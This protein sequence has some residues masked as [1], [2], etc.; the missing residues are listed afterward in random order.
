MENKMKNDLYLEH[1]LHFK[2]TWGARQREC[3]ECYKAHKAFME[4]SALFRPRGGMLRDEDINFLGNP[5]MAR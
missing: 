2:G 3:S 1:S 4:K 5:N